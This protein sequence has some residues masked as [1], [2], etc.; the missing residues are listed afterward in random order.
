MHIAWFLGRTACI[1]RITPLAHIVHHSYPLVTRNKLHSLGSMFSRS[2]CFAFLF[3]AGRSHIQRHTAYFQTLSMQQKTCFWFS[4]KWDSETITLIANHRSRS[5]RAILPA[6][7]DEYHL[8]DSAC[9]ASDSDSDTHDE[10]IAAT[11]DDCE[12]NG[13]VICVTNLLEVHHIE[14]Y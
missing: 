5:G 3:W 14:K 12:Y 4:L 13:S 11:D 1:S 10:S 9:E 6:D 2:F 7:V 8:A